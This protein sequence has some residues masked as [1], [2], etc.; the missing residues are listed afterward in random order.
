M[1]QYTIE[2]EGDEL[3]ELKQIVAD[4]QREQPH[5]NMTE[6]AYIENFLVGHLRQRV[7]AAYVKFVQDTPVSELKA[8]LGTRKEIERVN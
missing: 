4:I 1:A 5:L 8:M 7:T 3:E 6:Q 2:I